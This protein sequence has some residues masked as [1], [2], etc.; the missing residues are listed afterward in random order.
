MMDKNIGRVL[1]AVTIAAV[2]AMLIARPLPT[3]GGIC[4][5]VLL[6]WVMS[7]VSR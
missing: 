3:L 2:L 4:F 1:W 7:K 6:F 5:L